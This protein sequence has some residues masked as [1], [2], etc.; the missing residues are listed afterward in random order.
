M[1]AGGR[2]PE[3]WGR[4]AAG[5][6]GGSRKGRWSEGSWREGGT[7]GNRRRGEEGGR[8]ETSEEMGGPGGRT[9]RRRRAKRWENRRK[10]GREPGKG[11]EHAAAWR[12]MGGAMTLRATGKRRGVRTGPRGVGGGGGLDA[13]RSGGRRPKTGRSPAG[14]PHG[15]RGS[16]RYRP[17]RPQSIPQRQQLQD[18]QHHQFRQRLRRHLCSLQLPAPAKRGGAELRLPHPARGHFRF[19]CGDGVTERRHRWALGGRGG[20]FRVTPTPP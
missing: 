15:N 17:G 6:R 4:G 5:N 19:R 10:G 13:W 9:R 3:A 12:D 18:P 16:S 8:R 20:A 2:Q 1:G 14:A 7:G 11:S